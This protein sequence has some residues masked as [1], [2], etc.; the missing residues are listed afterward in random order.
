MPGPGDQ[1]LG[2]IVLPGQLVA[3]QVTAVI[4]PAAGDLLVVP[5]GWVPVKGLSGLGRHEPLV[6]QGIGFPGPV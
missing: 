5:G 3:D 1:V 4:E 2:V 6:Q